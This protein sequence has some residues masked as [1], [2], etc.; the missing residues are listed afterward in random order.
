MG[1]A[2]EYTDENGKKYVHCAD[3]DTFVS[4]S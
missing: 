3:P 2:D 4:E 1:P